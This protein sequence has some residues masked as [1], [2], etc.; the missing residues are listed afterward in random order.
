MFAYRIH[1]S[2]DEAVVIFEGDLDIESGD[3]LEEDILPVVSEY[4]NVLLNF[5][6][7]YFVDSSGIGLIIRTVDELREGGRSVK[8]RDVRPEVMEVFELLQIREILGEEVFD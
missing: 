6:E 7:V 1:K 8:I 5:G 2:E 3:V 4:P